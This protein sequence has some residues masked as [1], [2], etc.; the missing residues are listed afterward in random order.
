MY[1]LAYTSLLLSYVMEWYII[2]LQIGKHSNKFLAIVI[3]RSSENSLYWQYVYMQ[4]QDIYSILLV[5]WP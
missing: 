3:T 2:S 5:M 4:Q 1:V